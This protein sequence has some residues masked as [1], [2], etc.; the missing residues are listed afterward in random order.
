MT[1]LLTA[2]FDLDERG[3]PRAI[4]RGILDHYTILLGVDHCPTDT[5]AVTYNLHD[6][7]YDPVR[8]VSRS[9]PGFE[10][11]ISS[12]GDFEVRATLRTKGD[13]HVVSELLSTSLRRSYPSPSLAVRQAI[14]AIAAH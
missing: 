14:D 2:K 10:E 4:K 5:Y 13:Q 12:Y 3:E 9:T 8:Q 1:P 7:Y 6:S 11:Q